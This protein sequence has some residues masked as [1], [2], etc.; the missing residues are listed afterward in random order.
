MSPWRRE[1]RRS[2]DPEVT[3]EGGNSGI[4]STGLFATN[5]QVSLE[6]ATVLPPEYLVA[7]ENIPA[8]PGLINLPVR[9][10]LFVG[11]DA[12]L[13]ML[14]AGAAGRIAQVVHGLGGIGKSTLVARWAAQRSGTFP[15]V[16]WVTADTP[17][18][19]SAGLAGLIEALQTG[20][21]GFL[22]EPVLRERAIRWLA[23]HERWLLV[24]DNVTDPRH[25]TELM[26]RMPLDTTGRIVVTSR[27]ATGWPESAAVS[28]LG[29]IGL[30]A[31][32]VLLTAIAARGGV[33]V[34]PAA[35]GAVC[36][37]LGSLPLAVEQA[38][39]Y[40]AQTGTGPN[41]YLRLLAAQPAAMYRD[42]DEGR[43]EERTIARVWQVT[44]DAL[45]RENDDLPERVLRALAWYA[46]DAIPRFLTDAHPAGEVNVRRALGRLAAYNMISIDHGSD[47]VSV[48]RLVQAVTRTP[49]AGDRHRQAEDIE[50]ASAA[51][52]YAILQVLPADDEGV[53]GWPRWRALIP[54]LSAL[55]A[56]SLAATSQ[57]GPGS[58]D[59]DDALIK[60]IWLNRAGVFLSDQGSLDTSIT[61]LELARQIFSRF[62]TGAEAS[63][64]AA[65]NNLALGYVK[66]RDFGRAVPLL[67]QA[68]ADYHRTFG[69][70]HPS[71]INA[72]G[73]LAHAYSELGHIGAAISLQEK[74]L[75]KSRRTRGE[76]HEG[77]IQILSNLAAG[78]ESIGDF[79]R[80]LPMLEEALAS[81][82][83]A[84]GDE[85]RDTILSMNNL[86]ATLVSAGQIQRGIAWCEQAAATGD[87][88]LGD[89]H[90]QAIGI[91]SSLARAYEAAG[92]VSRAVVLRERVVARTRRVLGADHPDTL[93]AV[94]LLAGTYSSAGQYERAVTTSQKVIAELRGVLGD[95]HPETVKAI[96]R[97]ALIHRSADDH[98]LAVQ[99]LEQALAHCQNELGDVHPVTMNVAGNL[100]DA[101]REA[102]D[103]ERATQL[104]R[105]LLAYAEQ[106]NGT[107]H[108]GTLALTDLQAELDEAAGDLR[109]AISLRQQAVDGRRRTLGDAHPATLDSMTVLAFACLR[110]GE[111]E[112][113]VPLFEELVSHR[114][115][116]LGGD[117]PVALL[118]LNNLA[119][120]YQAVG[121]L[122]R[123]LPIFERVL[124]ARRRVVGEN[125]PD[126]L[127]SANNLAYCLYQRGDRG[128]A[129][130]MLRQ[131]LATC[132]EVL[133][134]EH[135]L[136]RTVR[137][138]LRATGAEADAG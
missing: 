11:R 106:A 49:D 39:A 74:I 64:L 70:E 76:D 97:L 50:G 8:P 18:N 132:R 72:E 77:T 48:H 35:A 120:A 43:P 62:G 38:G 31:A 51:A 125:H 36:A 121:D 137:S 59:R 116:A 5:T 20:A 66:S 134:E 53:S 34:D 63:L 89:G 102:D 65:T 12:A 138:G 92:D 85:H 117:H 3:V 13:T 119:G 67:E 113:A 10:D 124:A 6:N 47:T 115:S 111:A 107:D 22:K 45:V 71:T 81:R 127:T 24:L 16:W 78:Y 23:S 79:G 123:A 126:T 109:S 55:V 14:D 129:V 82:R 84:L 58:L 21:S 2:G 54:H 108:P 112:R 95:A 4:I 128:S 118:A 37:E 25:I 1:G 90:P 131:T 105:W 96:T 88:V 99:L 98:R 19:L 57:G 86:G 15:V 29:G 9:P 80:A 52:N 61:F 75:A 41:D 33:G 114:R 101:C 122:A 17:G 133:G 130:A 87:S 100:V 32:T 83:R 93:M 28:R 26:A 103:L 110:S 44:L 60:A 40:M 104:S 68:V 42:A 136:T 69:A 135:S 94:S 7:P 30:D 91:T 27:R 56:H 73:S 46:P